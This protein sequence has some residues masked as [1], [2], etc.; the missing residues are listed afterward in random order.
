MTDMPQPII[1]AKVD[2]TGFNAGM[3]GLV[4]KVGLNSRVVIKKETGE[5]IKELV[6]N[7]PPKNPTKTRE[8]IKGN[9]GKNFNILRDGQDANFEG[10]DEKTSSTGVKWYA[11]SPKYL[12]G[13]LPESDMRKSSQADLLQIHY[14]TKSV[15]LHKRV[16]L[17]FKNPR[18][19]QRVALLQ[20]IVTT[21]S[22]VNA[23]IR[24]IQSHVGRLKAAWL[25]PVVDGKITLSGGKMPPQWVTRHADGQSPGAYIDGLDIKGA[26]RFTIINRAKG[27]SNQYVNFFV[28]LAVKSRAASMRTN[29]ALLFS[30]KKKLSDYARN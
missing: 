16:I 12:Y 24:R 8:S 18:R 7:S 15:D 11:A 5:L 17:P 1:I 2:M 19:M 6:R 14:R 27:I 10:L 25:A 4:L 21:K 30:G 13:G 28:Q 23:L 29:A 22:Q 3:A 26:P 20:K 9:V